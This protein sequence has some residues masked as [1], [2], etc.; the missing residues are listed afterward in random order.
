MHTSYKCA[1]RTT[2]TC[3]NTIKSMH[4]EFWHFVCYNNIFI[5]YHMVDVWVQQAARQPDTRHRIPRIIPLPQP[6]RPGSR[7]RLTRQW[8]PIV[9]LLLFESRSNLIIIKKLFILGFMLQ[10]Y[11]MLSLRSLA[12]LTH[13]HTNNHIH[14]P[15]CTKHT[16]ICSMH[17]YPRFATT[18][19][20]LSV[21]YI[22]EIHRNFK[23]IYILYNYYIVICL[24]S[25]REVGREQTK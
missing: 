24:M 19:L 11:A 3:H 17:A 16:Y 25:Y 7:T 18:A 10:L 21:P 12:Q 13:I 22:Y 20:C 23:R 4:I 15:Q 9:S 14:I 1:R 6:A 5:Y 2:H 8:G